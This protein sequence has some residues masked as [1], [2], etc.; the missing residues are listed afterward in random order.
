M[1]NFQFSDPYSLLIQWIGHHKS[2]SYKQ[3][4][5]ACRTL[6]DL[7]TERIIYPKGIFWSLFR[8]GI[9]EFQGN[10]MYGLSSAVCIQNNDAGCC[11]IVNPDSNIKNKLRDAHNCSEPIFNLLIVSGN[12][13]DVRNSICESPLSVVNVNAIQRWNSIPLVQNIVK[14]LD[15][16]FVNTSEYR[17]YDLQTSSWKEKNEGDLIGLCKRD[18]DAMVHYFQ[19]ID[20]NLYKLPP[21]EINPDILNI[22]LCY[23]ASLQKIELLNYSEMDRVLKINRFIFPIILERFLRVSSIH[24]TSMESISN[25]GRYFA[26]VTPQSFTLIKNVLNLN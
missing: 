24:L 11:T 26:E 9:I 22:A 2:R 21:L 8:L 23:Q 25:V 6:S 15:T 1:S 12:N 5:E 14:S 17:F 18:K 19:D 13:S 10:G 3:V 16:V 7:A 20:N 4:L